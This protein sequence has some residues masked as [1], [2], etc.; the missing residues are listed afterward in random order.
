M[1]N[2]IPEVIDHISYF[3]YNLQRQVLNYVIKL[4]K[5]MKQEFQ[6]SGYCVLPVQFL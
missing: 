6:E 4:K 2:I 5:L 1:D 3:P